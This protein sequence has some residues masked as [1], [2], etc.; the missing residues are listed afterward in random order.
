MTDLSGVSIADAFLKSLIDS[1]QKKPQ[2]LAEA[3]ALVK[4]VYQKDISSLV[5]RFNAWAVADLKGGAAAEMATAIVVA[6][7]AAVVA[8]AKAV[9]AVAARRCC[10]PKA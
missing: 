6:E 4:Y 5:D 8:D 1:V 3:T 2:S 10:R 9:I 7:E